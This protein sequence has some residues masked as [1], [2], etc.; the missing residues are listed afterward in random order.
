MKNY[1]LLIYIFIFSIISI[2]SIYS[3]TFILSSNYKYIYIKQ[4]IWYLIGFV[5]MFLIMKTKKESFYKYGFFLYII[6]IILL[7]LVLFFGESINGSKAWFNIP[8][9]GAFQPSEF[10]KIALII[11]LSKILNYKDKNAIVKAFIITLIPS[12]L[13]FLEPD[14]GNVIIYI[15]IFIS[16]LYLRGINKKWFILI[17]FILTIL[18]SIIL[19]IYIFKKEVF[20]NFFSAKIFYRIDRLI[21]WK[22]KSGM[23]L[24]NALS[25]IGSAP[26]KGYGLT[27]TPIYFPE[28]QTD[29]I[30]A[31]IFSNLGI[32]FNIFFIILCFMFDYSILKICLTV[33]N[34]NK[35]LVFSI[36]S[37]LVYQQIQNIGMDLGLIPITGITMP[38][39]SYGGS[40]LICYMILIGL[41]MNINKK[42]S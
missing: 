26:K 38:F 42:I 32:Y 6:T 11:Y 20:I 15:I 9:L 36:L 25:A 13:T 39:I 40:S 8:K 41:I 24:D 17:T 23:Q 37:I 30:M 5:L 33:E 21:N 16:L 3:S 1:K 10:M 4:I 19:Y 29:F 12:I 34:K 31:I 22:N 18:I 2:L 27:K 14:T 28:A 7:I 35:Y